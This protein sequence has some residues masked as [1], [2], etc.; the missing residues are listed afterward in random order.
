MAWIRSAR[1]LSSLRRRFGIS[2]PKL[3]VRTHWSWRMQ[4]A[5]AVL[6][7]LALTALFY[8]GF[9]AGRWF[10]GF[11]GAQL[12]EERRQLLSELTRLR[13]ENERLLRENVELNNGAQMALGAR[14]V[15]AKQITQLQQENTQLKEEISFF[16]KLLGSAVGNSKGGLALQRLHAERASPTSYRLRALVVQGANESPFKGRLS[17]VATLVDGNRQTTLHLPEDQPELGPALA[18]NFKTYQ[19]ADITFRVPAGTELKSVLVRVHVG[20]G[21]APPRLQQTLQL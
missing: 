16:E 12:E 9:D 10:A 11:H 1:I 6:I 17:V 19:R 7:A 20:S 18:L 14:E 8:S 21:N 15:L 3:T 5:A 4:A 13:A 2:A